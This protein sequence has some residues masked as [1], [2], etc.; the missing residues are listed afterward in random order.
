MR[1]TTGFRLAQ[2]RA[3]SESAKKRLIIYD[4]QG[5]L[6]NQIYF[7]QSQDLKDLHV[8]ELERNIYLLDD[9]K[10]LKITF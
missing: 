7:P 1:V 2:A 5:N 8:D 10:L 4:Q 6:I 9:N 3:A